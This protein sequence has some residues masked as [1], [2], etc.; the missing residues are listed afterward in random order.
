MG[1]DI[2]WPTA[3]KSFKGS[4]DI[5][6][7]NAGLITKLGNTTS[8]V[9]PSAGERATTSVP[10]MVLPPGRFSTTTVCPRPFARCTAST[11]LVMSAVP[12]GGNGTTMRSDFDGK[13]CACAA[14]MATAIE[15]AA[16]IRAFIEWFP[17]CSSIQLRPALLD[18]LR[19]LGEV[20]KH[21]LTKFLGRASDGFRPVR[22][23]ALA[24]IRPIEDSQEVVVKPRDDGRGQARRPDHAVPADEL[25]SGQLFRHGGQIRHGGEALGRR[26]RERAQLARPHLDLRRLDAREIEMVLPGDQIH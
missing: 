12:P 19:A 21:E 6:R 9:W 18:E 8:S 16:K 23:D 22:H 3:L 4:N 15:T 2:V 25:E 5:S 7:R 10:M 1:T 20:G 24:H 26:D 13:V 11:R 17:D 14:P